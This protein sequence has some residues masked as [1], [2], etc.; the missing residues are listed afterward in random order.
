MLYV[1]VVVVVV[2]VDDVV[3][4]V[5]LIGGKDSVVGIETRYELGGPGFESRWG[6]YFPHPSR[7]APKPTRPPVQ[8]VPILSRGST[9]LVPGY[10]S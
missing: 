2:V 1:V 8:R 3:V 6:R 5:V 9:L 4:V 7:P 10:E